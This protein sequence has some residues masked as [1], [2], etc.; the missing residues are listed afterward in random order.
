MVRKT[1]IKRTKTK[2]KTKAKTKTL[3]SGIKPN[4]MPTYRKAI[5]GKLLELKLGDF[6]KEFDKVLLSKDFVEAERMLSTLQGLKKWQLLNL[7]SIL[8]Y[9]RDN[10]SLAEDLMRQALREPECKDVVNRNLAGLLVNQGRMVEAMHFATLAYKADK[11]DIKSI[12]LYMNCLLDMGKADEVLKISPDAIKHHPDNKIL[13]VSHASALRSVMKND[14]AAIEIK[15]LIEKFPEEPVVH[16]LQ[17]D[18]LGDTNSIAAVPF[19]EAA[20]ELSIKQRGEPDP[21]VQWNMSLHLLRIRRLE[22]GWECWEQ[23]FS[24][25]VGTMGRNLP[26]RIKN[27]SR[28]DIKGKKNR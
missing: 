5:P 7:N 13:L 18:L 25:I 20:V 9:K 17:A 10:Q 3:Q 23:G 8:E 14:E 16:R 27:L 21:A 28:A 2:T 11:T 26:A 22:Y 1:P 12:Q 15:K 24:P 6:L 4:V 19:Y